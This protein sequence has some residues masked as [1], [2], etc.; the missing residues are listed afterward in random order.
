MGIINVTC[1]I[2]I[3]DGHILACQKSA[4]SELALEWEFPGGKIENGETEEHCIVREMKEELAV[5]IKVEKKLIAVVHNYGFIKIRL[6][7][8]LC[9]IIGGTPKALEHETILWH[10]VG[11]FNDLNWSDADEKLFLV[12]RNDIK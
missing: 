4:D 3:V 7:P 6:I 11:C 2:V 10:P 1:A 8:F 5:D 9:S 12:N